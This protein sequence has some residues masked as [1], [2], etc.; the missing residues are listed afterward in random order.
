MA[1]IV[2]ARLFWLQ[3]LMTAPL[4]YGFIIIINRVLFPKMPF[5]FCSLKTND[6]LRKEPKFIVFLAQILLLFKFCNVCKSEK[7]VVEAS[8]S[9][10]MLVVKSYCI[11]SM[12]MHEETW[13]SQPKMPGTRLAAG[14]FL[15]SMATLLAG[16]S[17]SKVLQICK[18]M[19]L[20]SVSLVTFFKHQKV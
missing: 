16:G 19:G 3:N 17:F 1:Q 6:N 18:H 4:C 10:T 2:S 7:P 20:C 8:N 12:C 13:R 9:G 15:L 11:N 5:Y 14:N